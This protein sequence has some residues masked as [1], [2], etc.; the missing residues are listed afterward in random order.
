VAPGLAY[1]SGR[2][3]A[4]AALVLGVQLITALVALHYLKRELAQR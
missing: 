4:C 1:A 3:P 2:R